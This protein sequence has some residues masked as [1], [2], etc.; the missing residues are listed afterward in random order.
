MGIAVHLDEKLVNIAK[1]YSNA[2]SRSVAK[3]IEY[4]AKI[5]LLAEENPDLSYNAIRKILLGL[6]D[7]R[8]I[9]IK[10]YEKGDL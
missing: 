6:E 10:E 3:Q 4:W 8:N 2:L 5:G 1:T 7:A 9:N